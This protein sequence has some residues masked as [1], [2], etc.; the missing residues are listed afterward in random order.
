[1]NQSATQPV[2][3]DAPQ[4]TIAGTEGTFTERSFVMVK[5]GKLFL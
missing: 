4:T 1:M 3:L 2:Q 5:P